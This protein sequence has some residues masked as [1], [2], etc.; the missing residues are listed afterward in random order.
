M[1]R[2]NADR[3]KRIPKFNFEK[4]APFTFYDGIL[5]A[6]MKNAK[7]IRGAKRTTPPIKNSVA[8]RIFSC[9]SQQAPVDVQKGALVSFLARCGPRGDKEL[10]EQTRRN[11]QYCIDEDGRKFIHFTE[12]A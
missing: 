10:R 8:Q 6:K 9:L 11:F 12:N 4:D 7:S 1:K 2:K 3:S 5:N